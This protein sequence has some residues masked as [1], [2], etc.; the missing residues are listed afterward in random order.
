MPHGYTGAQLTR[1]MGIT[2]TPKQFA[3]DAYKKAKDDYENLF[4]STMAS[5]IGLSTSDCKNL[6]NIKTAWQKVVDA[7]KVLDAIKEQP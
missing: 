4:H 3:R 6:P 2:G 7:K 5:T 1:A